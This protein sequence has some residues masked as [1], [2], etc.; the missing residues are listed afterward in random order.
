MIYK[1]I[2]KKREAWL[3]SKDCQITGLVNYITSTGKMRDAQIEAIT[4]YLFLKIACDNKPLYQLMN[5]GYLN[6]IDIQELELKSSTRTFL[7]NNTGAVALLEY[8]SLTDDAG[9]IISPKVVKQI[10]DAPESI[11]YESVFK[12][13]FYDISYTDYLFTHTSHMNIIL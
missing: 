13:L 5:A 4:T 7:N 12:S 11:V 10:K 8:A 9:T 3:A 6:N 2:S 1:M